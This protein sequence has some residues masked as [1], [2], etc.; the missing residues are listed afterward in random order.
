MTELVEEE[1]RDRET[2]PEVVRGGLDPVT[3]SILEHEVIVPVARVVVGVGLGER[4]R[5]PDRLRREILDFLSGGLLVSRAEDE[6]RLAGRVVP[7][8]HSPQGAGGEPIALPVLPCDLDDD[9]VEAEDREL[10]MSER[11]R[12]ELEGMDEEPLLPGEEVTSEDILD[13]VDRLETEGRLRC[14]LPERPS[15]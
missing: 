10:V 5:G 9:R 6:G 4:V 2:A 7:H 13:E 8:E 3:R 15:P 1:I 12:L 11:S 14:Q